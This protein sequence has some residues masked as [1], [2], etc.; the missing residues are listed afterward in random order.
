MDMANGDVRGQEGYSCGT[1]FIF[2]ARPPPLKTTCPTNSG[3]IFETKIPS[4]LL[5]SLGKGG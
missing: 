5:I 3:H 1:I 4:F 2:R